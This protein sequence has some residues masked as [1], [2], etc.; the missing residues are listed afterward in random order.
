MKAKDFLTG[1]HLIIKSAVLSFALLVV[2][3][4]MGT[5]YA[6]VPAID[7]QRGYNAYHQ[8]NGAEG[9]TKTSDGGFVMVGFANAIP[10]WGSDVWIV[11]LDAGGNVIWEKTFG[12]N[13]VDLA[14]S[15]IQT[16]DGGYIVLGETSSVN[17]DATDNHGNSDV[18]I[19]RLDAAGT[20]IWKRCYGGSSNEKPGGI[21][22][23]ND[24]T[25][26]IAAT[27]LSNNGDLTGVTL[28]AT[29]ILNWAFSCNTWL[30]K[31]NA[32]GNILWQQ[33]Y[34]GSRDE[35]AEDIKLLADGGYI[36]VGKSNSNDGDVSGN[37]MNGTSFQDD[38][39][40]FRTNAAGSILWQKC[41]G[42]SSIDQGTA[43]ITT[44][45]GGYAA[46]GRSMSVDGDVTGLH[47]GG[48]SDIWVVKLDANGN[49]QWQKCLG[50]SNE[51]HGMNVISYNGNLVFAGVVESSDGD[52]TTTRI[53]GSTDLWLN[54]FDLSGNLLWQKCYGGQ[55]RDGEVTSNLD[56]YTIGLTL[57]DDG[58]LAMAAQSTSGDRPYVTDGN[59]S[60]YMIKFVPKFCDTTTTNT[61]K[62]ICANTQGPTTLTV[63]TG[64][65]HCVW[66]TGDTTVAIDIHDTGTYWCAYD[67]KCS[68]KIDTF[69]VSFKP[70]LPAL[71]LTD[72]LTLC[73]NTI[74]PIGYNISQVSFLWNTG[75]TE[76][77]IIPTQT[78]MYQLSITNGCTSAADSIYVSLEDCNSC[79]FIPN[80]FSPNRDGLNDE[81][82]A[83]PYCKTSDFSMNIYDRWGELVFS[84]ANVY[85]KWDGTFKGL[86][87]PVGTYFYTLRY[88]S[89]DSKTITRKGDITLIR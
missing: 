77:C 52:V 1:S 50:G 68:K 28:P 25:F 57:A 16:A 85:A 76:C 39:W 89:Q 15:V 43:I 11:K 10:N 9:V 46:I 24:G 21:V 78:G 22:Q 38:M 14:K 65:Q 73:N 47:P 51:D 74:Q 81:F 35:Y 34:G 86:A 83:I 63:P 30:F 3:M 13:D 72:S 82:S 69:V 6:Q 12:G 36:V 27:T 60:A 48:W 67:K 18:W 70:E 61:L 29:N 19:I 87:M 53:G 64:S 80:S 31:I 20:L 32:Q 7:W 66:N 71:S 54:A 23:N 5:A 2:L 37:H 56:L 58:G 26:T 88:Q 75:A 4:L 41:L 17:A 45:D 59:W 8:W 49:L 44:D 33:C 62:S 55:N 42:G 84:A 40:V 79:V